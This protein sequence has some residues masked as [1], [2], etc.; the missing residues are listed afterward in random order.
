MKL[1]FRVLAFVTLRWSLIRWLLLIAVFHLTA[2]TQPRFSWKNK[3]LCSYSVI[4]TSFL[5]FLSNATC[6]HSVT[7][8]IDWKELEPFEFSK[9]VFT[10]RKLVKHI[11]YPLD[12]LLCWWRERPALLTE[13][14]TILVFPGPTWTLALHF[15]SHSFITWEW[16]L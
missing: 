16:V 11:L 13:R 4:N 9:G 8:L 3:H 1:K 14:W 6:P 12:R 15:I 2:Y 7:P 10:E 5:K